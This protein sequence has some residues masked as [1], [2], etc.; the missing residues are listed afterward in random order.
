MSM[1]HTLLF[2]CQS[3][4]EILATLL[5]TVQCLYTNSIT[6][7]HSGGA[8]SAPVKVTRGLQQECPLSPLLYILYAANLE[9]ILHGCL[10]FQ[11][12]LSTMGMYER[13]RFPG[14]AFMTILY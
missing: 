4:M 8:L 6:I 1:Y 2:D 3:A 10:G 9:H 5:S 13:C 7:A 11:L 12:K 14:L